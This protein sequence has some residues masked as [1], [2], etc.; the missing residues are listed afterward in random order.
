VEEFKESG[1]SF[2]LFLV[3]VK[4]LDL[5]WGVQIKTQMFNKK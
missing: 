1:G 4:L 3:V 5:K 2:E